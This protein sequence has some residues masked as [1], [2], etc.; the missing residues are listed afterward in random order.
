MMLADKIYSEVDFMREPDETLRM[1]KVVYYASVGILNRAKEQETD[2]T[3]KY[4]MIKVLE[5]AAAFCDLMISVMGSLG[6]L[7]RVDVRKI[8]SGK[9]M[10]NDVSRWVKLVGEFEV[11][12]L[13]LHVLR[14]RV[15]EEM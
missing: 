11:L 12:R 9:L 7:A 15:A 3:L 10:I 4:G 14:M 13:F 1:A 5:D 6:N 2:P 8:Y